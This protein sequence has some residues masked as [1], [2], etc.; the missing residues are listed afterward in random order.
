MIVLGLTGISQAAGNLLRNGDFEKGL[1][2]WSVPGWIEDGL[3]PQLDSRLFH[4]VGTMSLRL[5]GEPGKRG[6]VRQQVRLPSGQD[7]TFRLTGWIRTRDFENNWTAG[8]R[9]KYRTMVDGESVR[10]SHGSIT[11]WQHTYVDWDRHEVEFTVPDDV[12]DL[13]VVLRTQWP[14][15]TAAQWS[16]KKNNRSFIPAVRQSYRLTGLS[17]P[18]AWAR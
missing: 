12:D 2:G 18:S 7:R 10:R 16:R 3:T 5:D 14:S 15:A 8:I 6:I 4:R 13:F 9:V 1:T 17:R 11:S